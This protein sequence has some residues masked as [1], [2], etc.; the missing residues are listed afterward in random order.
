[1]HVH[2]HAHVSMRAFMAAR[3]QYA[4]VMQCSSDA[5]Q[6][7]QRIKASGTQTRKRGRV[8]PVKRVF[9]LFSIVFCCFG[10]RKRVICPSHC[11]FLCHAGQGG[12]GGEGGE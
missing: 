5:M 10:P 2:T 9:S 7:P 11:C 4:A 8:Y 3:Q 1:M 6:L 12:Q